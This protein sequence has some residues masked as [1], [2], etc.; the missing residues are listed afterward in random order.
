MTDKSI[1]NTN[2]G[3]LKDLYSQMNKIIQLIFNKSFVFQSISYLI[4]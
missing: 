1:K 4:C 2:Q 3:F